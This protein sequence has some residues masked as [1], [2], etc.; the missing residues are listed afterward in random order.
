[1][2]RGRHCGGRWATL[3][4]AR[5]SSLF[6]FAW[7]TSGTRVREEICPLSQNL[8][9]STSKVSCLAFAVDCALGVFVAVLS[10]EG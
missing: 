8:F 2:S 6:T 5:F 3:L 4:S 7:L 1:M 10:V 9:S